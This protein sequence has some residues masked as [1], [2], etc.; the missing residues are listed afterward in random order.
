MQLSIINK[1]KSSTNKLCFLLTLINAISLIY[2]WPR[3]GTLERNKN[4]WKLRENT[5]GI[6]TRDIISFDGSFHRPRIT[7]I[8]HPGN[9]YASI[10]CWN[11]TRS[12]VPVIVANYLNCSRSIFST[13]SF[14]H[15]DVLFHHSIFLVDYSN[16]RLIP[17]A[18]RWWN[19]EN[20]RRAN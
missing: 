8:D 18:W 10:I 15:P 13:F 16:I 5:F 6:G 3:T 1:R 7:Q 9:C 20:K 12:F 2:I 4:H 17:Q 19:W 11:A 14:V